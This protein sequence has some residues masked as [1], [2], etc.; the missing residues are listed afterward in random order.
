[1]RLRTIVL[2]GAVTL[3]LL[4][5]TPSTAGAAPTET[6]QAAAAA[7]GKDSPHKDWRKALNKSQKAD[8]LAGTRIFQKSINKAH[9]TLDYKKANKYDNGRN[10]ARRQFAAGW[11]YWGKRISHISKAERKK[12]RAYLPTTPL[13]SPALLR[14]KGLL[15]AD[16]KADLLKAGLACTGVSK[17]DTKSWPSYGGGDMTADFYFNSCDTDIIIAAGGVAAVLAGVIGAMVK[18]AA[19][20]GI[21]AVVGG[22]MGLGAVW[23]DYCQRR[24]GVDATIYRVKHYIGWVKPQ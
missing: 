2:S 19:A 1:M 21:I 23:F 17:Q 16:A 4:A 14:A 20:T 13:P 10:T 12:V 3:A 18:H 8:V 15:T 22:I 11:L 7:A 5:G 9:T 6:A 24:S